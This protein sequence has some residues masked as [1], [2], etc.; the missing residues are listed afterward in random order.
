MQAANTTRVCS[1]VGCIKT[2]HARGFC[3]VHARSAVTMDAKMVSVLEESVE[4]IRWFP[5]ET[6]IDAGG[7]IILCVN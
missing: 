2:K 7:V 1:H 6:L 5:I 3:R 4:G